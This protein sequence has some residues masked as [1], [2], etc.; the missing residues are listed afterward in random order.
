MQ[1]SVRDVARVLKVNENAVYRWVSEDDL[2]AEQ[3]NGQ[4]RFNATELLEWATL[5]KL[6]VSP[7]L[8]RDPAAPVDSEPRLDDALAAG[9]ILHGVTGAD[10]EAVLRA[11]VDA[12]PVPDALD[13]DFLLEVLLSRESLGSTGIGDGLAIPHPRYPMV[14]PVDRPSITLCFL[15]QP[16]HYGAADTEPVH[17]LF[18]LVSPTVHVHLKLL[19]RLGIGLRDPLFRAAVARKAPAAEVLE[20]ARRLED[21]FRRSLRE[22]TGRL[23]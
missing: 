7:D 19:A 22:E 21:S 11:V 9:G 16:I 18:V 6:E 4:Y 12:M 8:F 1:L 23:P 3:I 13:R 10:T 2:P 15:D 14:L 20:H 17:T 5:R